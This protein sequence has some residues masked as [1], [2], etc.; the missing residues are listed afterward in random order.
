MNEP[1]GFSRRSFVKLA[2]ANVAVPFLYSH[3]VEGSGPAEARSAQTAHDGSRLPML[4]FGADDV[5]K[6]KEEAKNAKKVVW[7]RVLLAAEDYLDQPTPQPNLT[8]PWAVYLTC[9]EE[10]R[11]IVRSCSFAYLMTGRDEFHRRAKQ[12]ID[13]I[14]RWESWIDPDHARTLR[15]CLMTGITSAALAHYLDWCGP[16]VSVRERALIVEQHKRKAVKPLLADMAEPVPFFKDHINNHLAVDLSGTGLMALLLIDEEPVYREVLE[17]CAFHLRR[18]VNWIRDDGSTDEGGKYWRYGMEHAALLLDALR[19]NAGRLPDRLKWERVGEMYRLP[20]GVTS[21][22]PLETTGYF[23]LYCIQG[24]QYVVD[25]GDTRIEDAGRMQPLFAWLARIWR[26]GH[27]QWQADRLQSDNPLAFI[28]N[29]PTVDSKPPTDLAPSK[30]FHGAGWGILRSDLQDPNGFLLAIRAGHNSMT[31]RHHDLGTI[32]VRAGGRGLIV[33]SGHPTYSKDYWGG[34]QNYY[35]ETI[36]HNCILVDGKGQKYGRQNRAEITRLQ[37]LG[38]EKYLCVDIRCPSTGIELHRRRI[39]VK[40]SGKLSA[41]FTINDEIR[42][43][44]SAK[45]TWLF[46]FEKDADAEINGNRV[47]IKNGPVR[48]TMNVPP[49]APVRTAIERNHPVPL[50]SIAAES[51]ATHHSLEL[52]CEI[53]ESGRQL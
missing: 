14:L 28:W 16:A 38:N 27:F 48:L 18:Y 47:V 20:K 50:V 32:I 31:H 8:Q 51:K 1:T 42:L 10:R 5:P 35:R 13:A 43:A 6:L 40:L 53:E 34:K 3:N 12:E 7:H 17:K 49:D 21:R 46:H 22:T 15:Y 39:A 29:D 25:F 41:G 2:T 30:A 26:N 45:V 33:D 11:R 37:D 4:F 52:A 24:S 36:G 44:K 19:I 9:A 23:P